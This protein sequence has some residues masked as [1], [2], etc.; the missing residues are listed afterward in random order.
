MSAPNGAGFG[1][2][3]RGKVA[4]GEGGIGYSPLGPI[5]MNCFDL[6]EANMHLLEQVA[7]EAR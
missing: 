3:H 5:A 1:L 4:R 6:D 2:D 7:D